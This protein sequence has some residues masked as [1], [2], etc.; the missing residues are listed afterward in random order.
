VVDYLVDLDFVDHFAWMVSAVDQPGAPLVASARYIRTTDDPE[1]AEVAFG[2]GDDL[3]GRGIGTF[4]LGALAI[5]ARENGVFR[6]SANVLADNAPMRAVLNK[7]GASWAHGEP[8]VITT[9][10]RVPAP[11]A[12]IGDATTAQALR[13]SARQISAAASVALA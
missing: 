11:D 8:G 9:V 13:E 4:L 3:Q 12:L 1:T 5:A 7:A 2:V 10:V 6:F